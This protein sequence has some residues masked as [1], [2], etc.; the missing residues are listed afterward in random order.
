M[1]PQSNM[2]LVTALA[3]L[4]TSANAVAPVVGLA[5]G[6]YKGK[7]LGNGVTQWLGMRYA[8]PPVGDLRFMPPQDPVR[9]RQTKD[10]SRWKLKCI[11]G[12]ASSRLIGKTQSEDCLF[13]NVF[14]PTN[15]TTK[16]KL[17]V[18]FYIQGG[19]FN[20]NSR[21]TINGTALI[22]A[23]DMNMVVVTINYRVSI[24]GFLTYG[25]KMQPNIGLLDQRKALQWVNKHIHKF[26][27]N[28]KHVTIGGSSSGGASVAFHL[29]AYGGRDDRLF[30][31][32]AAESM[33]ILP[34]STLEGAA[35][36]GNS[37]AA[38]VN[39]TD[40]D[41]IA[42]LRN[43]TVY[44]I[45]DANFVFP[46]PGSTTLPESMW[47][48]VVDGTFVQDALYSSFAQGKFVR[49]P[50]II[51]A[52]TNEGYGFLHPPNPSSQS[53]V[54]SFF[55]AEYPLL[56]ST[57]MDQINAL[58]PNQNTACPSSGC[59][60]GQMADSYGDTRFMCPGVNFSGLMSSWMPNKTWNYWYNVQD[61]VGGRVSHSAAVYAVWGPQFASGSPPLSYLAGGINA[62]ETTV[63]QAYWAS[64]I[65]SYDPNTFRY[66]NTS[67]WGAYST[68]VRQRMVFD[69][70]GQTSTQNMTQIT[71]DRC[72]YFGSIGTLVRQ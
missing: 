45:Q 59:F 52:T 63:V 71:Q 33:S 34:T 1:G 21:P 56:N 6:K 4:L 20:S 12:G 28:P 23:S 62:N 69:S 14:A 25:D 22:N 11:G 39:C 43:K 36:Q 15:A 19:G 50:S 66:A 2:L 16:S 47:G 54:N 5:Y 67:L 65:R 32:A 41:V 27:G 9:S 42:C 38:W 55:Q 60:T 10:A 26:G 68:A 44:E 57:Q 31:A 13:I 29:T 64:F 49:V 70:A 46:Y 3:L 24:F 30:H 53:E 40:G 61:T 58:Y 18:F 7:D 35:Y 17:P 51:G 72:E 37:V 8:A 48:P